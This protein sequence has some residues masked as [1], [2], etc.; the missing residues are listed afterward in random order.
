MSDPVAGASDP[1]AGVSD[2]VAGVFVFGPPLTL[3]V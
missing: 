3:D 2:P 1:V